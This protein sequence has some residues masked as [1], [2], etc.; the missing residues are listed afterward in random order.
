MKLRTIGAGLGGDLESLGFEDRL[1]AH[2]TQQLS[3]VVAHRIDR[4]V[5]AEREF[6]RRRH[7]H[8]RPE[9]EHFS[10]H[11]DG[12]QR[13]PVCQQEIPHRDEADKFAV[14]V[15]HVAISDECDP[16]QR[17]QLF[18][19][20]IHGY[21]GTEQGICRLHETPDVARLEGPVAFPLAREFR[22][23]NSKDRPA[24]FVGQYAKDIL[25]ERGIELGQRGEGLRSI[26]CFEQPGSLMRGTGLQPGNQPSLQILVVRLR[27]C[28]RFIL[29]FLP[30]L[31]FS[32]LPRNP[33]A[34]CGPRLTRARQMMQ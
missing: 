33:A 14:L 13:L 26:G 34:R 1:A 21:P 16:D 3:L 23:G 20:L 15:H 6:H 17:V 10:Q 7:R 29:H 2:Q 18:N 4:I 9:R 24:R 28:C 27:Y 11:D 8:I 31:I 22:C 12:E 5:A 30:R 32:A 25:G 19:G